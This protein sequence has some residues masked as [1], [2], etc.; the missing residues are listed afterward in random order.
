M[1]VLQFHDA[2]RTVLVILFNCNSR[3]CIEQLKNIAKR[4][5]KSNKHCITH[6]STHLDAARLS[7]KKVSS[8][9]NVLPTDQIYCVLIHRISSNWHKGIQHVHYF[10]YENMFYM[11]APNGV[12]GLYVGGLN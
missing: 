6:S 10:S 2:S 4:V 5:E 1:Y 3:N 11:A 12:G 7:A 8:C 9:E